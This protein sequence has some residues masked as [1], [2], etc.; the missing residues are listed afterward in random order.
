MVIKSAK[1]R[2]GFA[3]GLVIFQC[4]AWVKLE[5]ELE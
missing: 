1:I 2:L 3:I 4:V 5:Q